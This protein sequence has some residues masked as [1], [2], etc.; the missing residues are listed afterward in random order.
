MSRADVRA[1]E[2]PISALFDLSEDVNRE[3][4]RFRKLVRYAAAF[5]IIWLAVDF[6][7][8]VA[9]IRGSLLV[10]VALIA[11]FVLGLGTLGLLANLNDFFRYYVAR[12]RAIM[13]VRSD[14]PVIKVPPGPTPVA[15]LLNHLRTR[16]P[17]LN[18]L[19][20]P[21]FVPAPAKVRGRTGRFHPLDAHLIR[22]SGPFWD[23][24][25]RGYP[26]YQIMVRTFDRAPRP[27]E[28]VSLKDAAEDISMDNRVPPSRV[29]ALWN[30][31]QD[32]DLSEEAYDVLLSQVA[33]S[34]HR[35]KH[36]ASSLELIIE[37]PDDTYEFIPYIIDQAYF[38]PS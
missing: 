3:A 6:V 15:R 35:G 21:N 25:G 7:L 37:G 27:E 31:R 16:N 5:I 36:F 28:L 19:Y 32:D 2:N 10:G 22:R 1:V 17:E 12:H 18:Y 23:L 24:L 30:R 9:T 4:P 26:G 34:S 14:D 38:P 29:I 20:T 13:S 8:I 33:R 11:I